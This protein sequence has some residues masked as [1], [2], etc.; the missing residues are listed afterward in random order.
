MDGA[1]QVSTPQG[2]ED[3]VAF[4]WKVADKLRGHFKAHEYGQVMLPLLVLRRLDC[5]LEPTK[6]KVLAAKSEGKPDPILRRLAGHP[7]WNTSPQTFTS[8]LADDKNVAT[9]LRQYV[10]AFSPAAEEVLEAY[11]LDAA[12][13]RL[14][15]AQILYQVLGDF[16]DLDLRPEVVSNDAMGAIFEELLRKFSEMSNETG[17]STTPRARSSASWWTCCSVRT[18]RH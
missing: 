18:A 15:K 17:V 5:V 6:A 16:A 3:K 7:F 11:H 10:H 1:A 14:D 9:A 12:I 13:A 2:F 8:L 4:V